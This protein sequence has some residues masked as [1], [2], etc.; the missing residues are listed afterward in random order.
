MTK[1]N[2]AILGCGAI[3]NRH[4]AAIENNKANF[5]LVGIYDPINEL[6][7]KYAAELNLKAY[8]NEDELYADPEINLVVILSPS[9]LHYH[10]AM[11]SIES[12][13]NVLIEKP[14][15]FLTAEIDNLNCLAKIQNVS[16]F[17]VLQVRLN[18]AVIIA[19]EA[20]KTG[21]LG[22]FYG[23]SLIQ[24]WQRPES[25]FVG[26]RGSRLSGGGILREFGIHYLDIVQ[27]LAGVP[28]ISH[29]SFFNSKFKVGDVSDTI[30]GLFDFQKFGGSFEI[31]VAAEPKN[32]ECSLSIMSENGF[33]QLGGKSLDEIVRIEFNKP[34]LIEQFKEIETRIKNR[35]TAPLVSQGASP[36][37]PELYRQLIINPDMFKLSESF[38]VIQMIEDAYKFVNGQPFYTW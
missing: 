14:A 26:W 22:N 31:S 34:E 8:S 20:I 32:L 33:L 1:Y 29:A 28:K 7:D 16:I 37:H 35:D 21:L 4:L 18:S 17:C 5:N 24:R 30:Y 6:K 23:V 2:V 9:N 10:Q 27:F 38:N 25:Y 12:K 15:T 3:F 36:Y 11:R 19:K 13:K